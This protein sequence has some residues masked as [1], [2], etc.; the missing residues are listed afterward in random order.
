MIVSRRRERQLDD[1]RVLAPDVNA[2]FF[3]QAKDSAKI[4]SELPLSFKI[5]DAFDVINLCV[6]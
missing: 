1:R 4:L 3:A 5:C 6:Y 2:R